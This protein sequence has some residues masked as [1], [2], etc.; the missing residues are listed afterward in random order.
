MRRRAGLESGGAIF[1]G[2]ARYWGEGESGIRRKAII[3]KHLFFKGLF[4]LDGVVP[5][6][7]PFNKNGKD[8]WYGQR[9]KSEMSIFRLFYSPGSVTV[10]VE[11]VRKAYER[12][13]FG[14]FGV[15]GARKRHQS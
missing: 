10:V 3:E 6:T 9:E 8:C 4:A 2:K 15:L 1:L 11:T 5:E 13:L 14:S 7:Y 12:R